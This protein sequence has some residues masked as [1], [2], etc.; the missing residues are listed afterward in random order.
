MKLHWQNDYCSVSS[1]TYSFFFSVDSTISGTVCGDP[2]TG[3]WQIAYHDDVNSSGTLSH[4]DYTF[5]VSLG[6]SNVATLL[7]DYEKSGM[8]NSNLFTQ[9]TKMTYLPGSPA[10]VA[11]HSEVMPQVVTFVYMGNRYNDR[12]TPTMQDVSAQLQVGTCQGG[13]FQP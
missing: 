3:S 2:G 9:T 7:P 8:E 5:T 10:T 1:C 6:G 12:V 13:T 11:W 4:G